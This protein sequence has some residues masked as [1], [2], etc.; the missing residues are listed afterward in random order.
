MDINKV[1]DEVREIE[2][3][4]AQE[5]AQKARQAAIK[6]EEREEDWRRTVKAHHEYMRAYA[7]SSGPLKLEHLTGSYL[8]KSDLLEDY[9]NQPGP[10]LLDVLQQKNPHGTTAALDMGL[11]EGTA[12]LALSTDPLEALRQDIEVSSNDSDLDSNWGDYGSSYG[13]K[14][15]AK[16]S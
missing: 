5:E 2:D 1:S 4:K 12:L 11:R 7:T 10:I 6:R 8:V 3:E 16:Q 14:R 13:R 15:K 9:R